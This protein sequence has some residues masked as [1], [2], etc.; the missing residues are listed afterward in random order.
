MRKLDGI[1]YIDFRV[2]N[3]QEDGLKEGDSPLSNLSYLL[4]YPQTKFQADTS[5]FGRVRGPRTKKTA[6]FLT[7]YP[8][9]NRQDTHNIIF[10]VKIHQEDGFEEGESSP[11]KSFLSS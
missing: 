6:N 3:D 2:V 5:T 10:R 8:I 1:V 11:L 7:Y 4:G 9:T